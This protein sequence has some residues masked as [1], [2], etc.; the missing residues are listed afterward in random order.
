[1]PRLLGQE[2][3]ELRT[4]LG[5]TEGGCT[6]LDLYTDEAHPFLLAKEIQVSLRQEKKASTAQHVGIVTCKLTT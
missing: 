4:G 3:T 2:V 1:M 6:L 5:A